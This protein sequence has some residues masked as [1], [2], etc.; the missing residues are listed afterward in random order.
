MENSG[1]GKR[2]HAV[3]IKDGATVTGVTQVIAVGEKE[4]TLGVGSR[5][6]VLTG[7][8]FSAEKLSIEEGVI[9]VKGEVVSL[10]Y[11]NGADAKGFLKK[12]FK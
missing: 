11:V 3:T 8:G 7:N 6:L 10:K 2:G 4:I 9:V 12:I 5:T 1:S